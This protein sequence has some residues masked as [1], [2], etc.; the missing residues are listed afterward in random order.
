MG[1][2]PMMH[3]D[4]EGPQKAVLQNQGPKDDLSVAAWRFK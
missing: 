1:K 3:I 2:R 4:S